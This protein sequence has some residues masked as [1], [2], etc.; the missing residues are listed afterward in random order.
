MFYNRQRRRSS[1]LGMLS[2]DQDEKLHAD[3]PNAA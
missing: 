3:N 1:S 2:P